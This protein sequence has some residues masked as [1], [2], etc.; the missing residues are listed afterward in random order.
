[1]SVRDAFSQR[2]TLLRT[3]YH[4]TYKDLS[5]VLWLNSNSI[6]EWILSNRN[7]PNPDKLVLLADMYA[8][9][10]DWLLGRS[11]VIY[12]HD[13]LASVEEKYVIGFLQAIYKIPL[14]YKD[15]VKRNACYSFGV[16]AN[17]ITLTIMSQYAAMVQVLD[18]D[19]YKKDGY[20]SLV[21]SNGIAIR[22]AFADKLA[23]QGDLVGRLLR[24][25]KLEA[26]FDVEYA[27]RQLK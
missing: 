24:R 13:V 2:F 6:N 8:V 12:S 27:F 15:I 3:V 20:V 25:E 1:M 14:E 26:P 19:F 22:N 10:L 7:F 23:G 4:H 5:S 16:R 17:I 9:S 18:K 11:D 21:E